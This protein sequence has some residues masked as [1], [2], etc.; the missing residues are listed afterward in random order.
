M[1]KS[2]G[3]CPDITVEELETMVA[4]SKALRAR[5]EIL[6]EAIE[7]L[8]ALVM[9]PRIVHEVRHK[10]DDARHF[11]RDFGMS[12]PGCKQQLGRDERAELSGYLAGVAASSVPNVGLFRVCW[13]A[14]N[15]RT[16]HARAVEPLVDALTRKQSCKEGPVDTLADKAAALDEKLFERSDS[17]ELVGQW[18]QTVRIEREL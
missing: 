6:R 11:A 1:P 4:S 17:L 13:V 10:A 16:Y 5:Q 7:E 8:T 12:C 18:P 9:R 3:G 2:A 14:T 15:S